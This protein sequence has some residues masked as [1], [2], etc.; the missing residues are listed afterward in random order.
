MIARILAAIFGQ[1]SAEPPMTKGQIEAADSM[2]QAAERFPCAVHGCRLAPDR[3]GLSP[4]CI[5][6]CRVEMEKKP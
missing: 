1:P 6:G 4:C 5:V 2:M 3:M